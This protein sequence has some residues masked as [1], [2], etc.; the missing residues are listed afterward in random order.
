[1]WKRLLYNWTTSVAAY[2]TDNTDLTLSSRLFVLIVF[3]LHLEAAIDLN[4]TPSSTE[5]RE[6]PVL[7]TFDR[8]TF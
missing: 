6:T 7:M 1:M 4:P 8:M 3:T 5:F 2:C